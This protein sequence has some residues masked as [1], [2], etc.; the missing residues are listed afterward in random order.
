MTTSIEDLSDDEL[1]D[2]ILALAAAIDRDR[3]AERYNWEAKRRPSQVYPAG[4]YT[5]LLL[6][7]AGF[8]KTRTAAEE[9]RRRATARPLH[10]AVIHEGDRDVR[11]LCF[12]HPTSGLLAVIPPEEIARGRGG[13]LA[14]VES[15]GDTTL[16][17]RNGSV[18]RAFSSNDP[19]R[20]RGFAFDGYWCEEFAAWGR[21]SS[22]SKPTATLEM[23]DFRLREATDPFGIITT[24][25]KRVRH[26]IDLIARAK[27]PEEGIVVTSGSTFENAAN[28]SPVQMARLRRKYPP[29]SALGRQELGGEML[30]E[31]EG[32]LWKT[33]T[34]TRARWLGPLPELVEKI[35]VV[36]PSGSEDG[37][38][39]GIVTLGRARPG[40]GPL[41]APEAVGVLTAAELETLAATSAAAAEARLEDPGPIIVLADDSTAGT[42]DE[43]YAAVCTTAHAH[44]V[45]VIAYEGNYGGDNVALGIRQTWAELQRQGRIPGD[46]LLPKLV[47]ISARG[48]KYDRAQPVAALYPSAN[49]PVS[50]VWHAGTFPELEEEQTT[51]EANATWSP[52]RLDALVHGV[53]YFLGED[54]GPATVSTSVGIRRPT[55]A[56]LPG[57]GRR[58][59]GMM[60]RP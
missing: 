20:L 55:S 33:S 59:G 39:T 24:T 35:T 28:L 48:S 36:D 34:L 27:D 58:G 15:S 30:D 42:P 60:R 56:R 14:Y 10:I 7:G 29:G 57:P 16:T 38:A 50:G 37:D 13:R 6:A 31:V 1:E 41:D 49:R 21:K 9:C 45:G 22:I 40:T 4:A 54:K 11:E 3:D 19:D 5:W 51:F 46:D 44:G 8:G 23:L 2:Q 25:P 47:P 53:R 18:F 43:R 52:N 17:L 12:E 26:L 32:A